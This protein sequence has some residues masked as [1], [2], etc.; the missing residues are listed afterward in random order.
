MSWRRICKFHDVFSSFKLYDIVL[1]L[2]LP[3]RTLRSFDKELLTLRNNRWKKAFSEK[4]E[5]T[6]DLKATIVIEHIIQAADV[7]HTMQH[8]HVYQKWN[9]KLFFEM[10]KAYESG[11]GG[12]KDPADTWY[13]GELWFFDNYVIPLAKKLDECGVFGVCSDECLTYATQNR[14]EWASKGRLVVESMCKKYR[15]FEI[16]EEEESEEEEDSSN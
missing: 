3:S 8:W 10:R 6:P 13:N 16:K 15:E 11:R 1:T 14:R 12:E 5:S 2:F 4:D 7:A 9:E